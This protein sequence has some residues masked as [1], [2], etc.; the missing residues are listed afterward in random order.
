MVVFIN[1]LSKNS[2]CHSF[3]YIWL[4]ANERPRQTHN[5]V[6]DSALQND[7][8][9]SEHR[10]RYASRENVGLSYFVQRHLV[11]P[12]RQVRYC[13]TLFLRTWLSVAGGRKSSIMSNVIDRV[14]D[15][16][17]NYG[18]VVLVFGGLYG[19]IAFLACN[20]DKP[21]SK[22][23]LFASGELTSCGQPDGTYDA[24]ASFFNRRTG[25]EGS[26]NM[27]VT[28]RNCVLTEIL[29]MDGGER[30]DFVPSGI[31]NDGRAVVAYDD[32]VLEIEIPGFLPE[33]EPRE[34]P[35]R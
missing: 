5:S 34:D 15:W 30:S 26:C 17:S 13:L 24:S 6:T 12:V 35:R 20:G 11:V 19:G 18:L 8:L 9:I 29:F 31:T 10:I 27:S 14:R 1:K 7:Q 16:I 33:P 2:L 28:V 22:Q 25:E 3:F 21:L 4:P 32:L 23:K